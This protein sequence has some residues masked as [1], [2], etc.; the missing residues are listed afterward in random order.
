MGQVTPTQLP[1]NP[2]GREARI[3]LLA[4]ERLS[5]RDDS[6]IVLLVHLDDGRLFIADV[7]LGD[8]PGR[9]FELAP[10]A[11]EEG[12]FRFRLDERDGGVWRFTHDPLGSFDGFDVDFSSSATGSSEFTKYHTFYW[13]HPRSHFRTC[14]LV[15][16]R[17]SPVGGIVTLRSCTL[18]RI[19][20]SLDGGSTVLATAADAQ[21]QWLGLVQEHFLLPLDSLS[22]Q[23]RG[24]LWKEAMARHAAWLAERQRGDKTG[25]R[26][27]D[28]GRLLCSLLTS[29]TD[30][31]R[32]LGG[33]APTSVLELGAGT[34]EL[35]VALARDRS[36]SRQLRRYIATDVDE[37]TAAITELA[38][39]QGVG[40]I[41]HA[42]P[43]HWGTEP[44]P[45]ASAE[46]LDLVLAS[47]VLYMCRDGRAATDSIEP[48]AS[49]LASLCT[50]HCC[51]GLVVF[52]ARN[53]AREVKF[54]QLCQA[55]GLRVE[56][57]AHELVE[58]HAPLEPMDP[59]DAD[60][61]FVLLRVG[62]LHP[63]QADAQHGA[64]SGQDDHSSDDA[65]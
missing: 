44:A 40:S 38:Q 31:E 12:G 9:P 59:S 54:E 36:F 13:T 49:T 29:P 18:K 61:P 26:L 14:G 37:R 62:R 28:G 60:C 7:G 45:T 2:R 43:L 11:W 42:V 53:P 15:L 51:C 30:A 63:A 21:E 3:L 56:R 4:A 34:G 1:L 6:H 35:A 46:P 23:Q 48:L 27:W 17:M 5:S 10:G 55:W 41:V 22:D 25:E 39:Q 16:Q 50:R 33:I 52:R 57:C 58:A 47:E 32:V 65:D 8:G 24:A 20:P 19:H 64:A